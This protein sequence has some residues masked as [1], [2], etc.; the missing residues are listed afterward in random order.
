MS[1]MISTLFSARQ[2][3]SPRGWAIVGSVALLAYGGRNVLAQSGALNP[4]FLEHPAVTPPLLFREVWQ[5][6]PHSGP[7]NDENRRITQQAV[8]HPD[9]ELRLY[10]TDA[11]NIQVTEHNG[12]PDVW[13]GFTTSPVALTLRDKNAYLDLTGLTRMR[14]RTRTENLHVLHPVVKLADGTL[15]AG[16]QTF[17]SPQRRMVGKD[18]FTGNFVVS[19]VTFD[20]QRW[21]RLDPVKVVTTLEVGEP[22]LS[23]VDEIGFVDL[24]PGGGHGTAGCSN[25]S[26]IEVYASPR[27]R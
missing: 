26:W 12:I 11:R 23:R 27:K 17:S 18:A 20:D 22:D 16:S 13:T 25:V 7:L 10:G 9:L 8:T 6:P 2:C 3:F 15:L 1:I 19:E 4:G 14:W 24:M 5:Q 21:F